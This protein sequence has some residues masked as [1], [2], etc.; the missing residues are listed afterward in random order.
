MKTIKKM[1]F[2]LIF[3]IKLNKKDKSL[4]LPSKKEEEERPTPRN[5]L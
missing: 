4:L 5:K 2:K 3:S 1:K